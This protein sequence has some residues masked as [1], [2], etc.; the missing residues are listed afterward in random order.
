MDMGLT[1]NAVKEEPVQVEET[2]DSCRLNMTDVVSLGRDADG[3][4]TTECVGGDWSAEVKQEDLKQEPDDVLECL[5]YHNQQ[6]LNRVLV[7]DQDFVM[8]FLKQ[9]Q[10]Y[11]NNCDSVKHIIGNLSV[12]T[13]CLFMLPLDV[14]AFSS[15]MH[16]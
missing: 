4:C 3:P 14:K 15:V 16:T 10:L 8:S 1:V 6:E 5:F 7:T 11:L 2:D 13:I 12:Q 9:F